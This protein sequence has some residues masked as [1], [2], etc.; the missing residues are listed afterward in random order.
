[1]RTII[2]SL[3][4]GAYLCLLSVTPAWADLLYTNGPIIAY[5]QESMFGSW[6][7]HFFATS[8]A[9]TLSTP[10]TVTEATVGIWVD[11]GDRP[12]TIAY[13]IGDSGFFTS[14]IAVGSAVPLTNQ[15][16]ISLEWSNHYV[17]DLYASTFQITTPAGPP[18]PAGTYYLTLGEPFVQG[19]V[20]SAYGYTYL[21]WE[22]THGSGYPQARV[23]SGTTGLYYTID[24]ESFQIY[25]TP[26]T[27]PEPSIMAFLGICVISLVGLKR[28]WK[29]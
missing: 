11:Q 15:Y 17:Y 18:L 29:D 4:V 28:W 1:M 21:N 5:P 8:D 19:N 22:S 23:Y 27:V 6:S 25:G 13:S 3:L 9:F 24:S 14:N 7:G 20:T 10:S 26:A 12:L 2:I 16:V